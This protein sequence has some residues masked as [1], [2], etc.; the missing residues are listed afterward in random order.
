VVGKAVTEIVMEGDTEDIFYKSLIKYWSKLYGPPSCKLCF[1]NIRGVG[2]FGSKVPAKYKNEICVK[3]PKTMHNIF[4]AYDTDVFELQ[5][6]PPVDW[7]KIEEKLKS[8][9]AHSVRHIRAE[10]TIEDWLLLDI[11]GIC[12]NLRKKNVTKI[13]GSSGLEKIQKLFKSANRIYQKG[14]NSNGL[15]N[16]LDIGKIVNKLKKELCELESLLYH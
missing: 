16:S 15:V 3:Y 6:K 12:Q 5:Q 2:R 11:E 10:K 14:Y 7:L 4:L 8:D 13:K 1:M 9:G